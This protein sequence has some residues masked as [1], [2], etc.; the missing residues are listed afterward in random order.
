MHTWIGLGRRGDS[1][2]SSF[3]AVYILVKL[4]MEVPAGHGIPMMT[5]SSVLF[6]VKV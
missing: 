4:C 3:T 2:A 6:M 5:I 1:H